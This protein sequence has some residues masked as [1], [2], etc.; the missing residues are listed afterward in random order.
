MTMTFQGLVPPAGLLADEDVL[1]ELQR[2]QSDGVRAALVTLVG[3]EGGAPRQP[4]DQMAVAEDGRFAGYLSGGCLEQA[5]VLEA[6]A[7]MAAGKNRLVRYGKGSPYFDIELPCGSGLDLYFDQAIST[8]AI[9]EIM[10]LRNGRRACRLKTD[11]TTG[12][13]TVAE[14]PAGTRITKSQ[15]DGETFERVYSPALRLLLLGQG[16]GL[17]GMAV[18]A[19]AMGIELTVAAPDDATRAGLAAARPRMCVLD[20]LDG[21]SLKDLDYA[22]AVVLYFHDHHREPALL[23]ELLRSNC[24]Y[25]GALGNHAVHRARL[26]TL[27]SQGFGPDDLARIRAPVGTIPGAK[28]KATLAAGVLAQLL[29]DAKAANLIS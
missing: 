26:E 15:R 16:P 1:P 4:G 18:L 25:I 10:A 3:V 5:V 13:S 12:R 22:T 6:K 23:A 28:S 20:T 19:A 17:A 27:A 7:A 29:G 24:F 2:W 9:S 14:L 21:A 8:G 11:L